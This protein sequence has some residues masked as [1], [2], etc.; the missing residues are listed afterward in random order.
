[1]QEQMDAQIFWE[2]FMNLLEK[3]NY[4]IQNLPLIKWYFQGYI[5]LMEHF[6]FILLLHFQTT[7]ALYP[8]TNLFSSIASSP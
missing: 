7:I 4:I 2:Q 6:I 5:Y 1:M 8:L 3:C